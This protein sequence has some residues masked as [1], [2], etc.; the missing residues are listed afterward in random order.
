MAPSA[1]GPEPD[2]PSFEARDIVLR[3]GATVRLRAIRREDAAAVERLHEAMSPRSLYFRFLGVPGP[4]LAK[5]IAAMCAADGRSQVVLVAESGDRIVAIAGYYVDPRRPQRAEV[6]FTVDDAL[7][8]QGLGTRMLERL[9]E[10]AIHSS[11]TVIANFLTDEDAPA[12]LRR[13]PS[14]P[15]PER[16]IAALSH[17]ANYAAWKRRPAGRVPTFPAAAKDQARA[18]VGAVL[19]RGGGWLSPPEIEKLLA[20]YSIPLAPARL[21]RGEDDAVGAAKTLGFPVVLK[22]VGPSIIH[23]TEAGAI[24]LNL[25][26]DEAVRRAF[27]DLRSRL[28]F[29]MTEALVQRQIEGGIEVI[30]GATLDPTFGPLILYGSGGTLVELLGDVTFRLPPVTDVDAEAML[31]EV[32]GTQRLRGW[33]GAP[34]ADEPALRAMLTRVSALVEA[35]PEIR[36][37]DFNPVAVL[38]DGVAVLDARVRVE[39]RSPAP[40]SRRIAY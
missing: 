1:A 28:A 25:G 31:G 32:R 5:Q 38:P 8:G 39:R 35:A 9:A 11:K 18:T 15:F 33:R 26:T 10:V 4:S 22:A 20:A 17:A 36:E 12:A 24:R 16:A 14:Y 27:R 21:V 40:P 34:R 23:K 7:Q 6:A 30:V 19:E 29:S 37:L 13:I 2:T 3:T